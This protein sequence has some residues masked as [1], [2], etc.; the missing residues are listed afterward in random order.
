MGK[1]STKGLHLNP[2]KRKNK[3]HHQTYFKKEN[4][5]IDKTK[6]YEVENNRIELKKYLNKTVK[7]Q[8]FVTNTYGYEGSKRLLNSIILPYNKEG[9]DKKLY[10]KHAWALAE[11]VKDI[12]HG[13]TNVIV[14]VIK[15]K[16]LIDNTDK[17]G[18]EIIG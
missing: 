13:Y 15:Y 1:Y 8:A 2:K 10:I 4:K 17:Y 18:I 11:T 12:P 3:N 5:K 7:A 6:L 16:N 9:T 14:H